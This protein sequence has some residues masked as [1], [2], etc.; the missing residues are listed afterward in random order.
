MR[1]YKYKLKNLS[2]HILDF[3]FPALVWNL[4]KKNDILKK[5]E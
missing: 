3:E 5:R 1:Y 4:F 2:Y